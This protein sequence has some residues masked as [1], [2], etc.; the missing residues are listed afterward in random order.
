L[1]AGNVPRALKGE[2]EGIGAG[3]RVPTFASPEPA[4]IALG[5]VARYADWRRRDVGVLP[6]YDDVD[7]AAARHL[8]DRV[9]AERP[10]GRWLHLD[11]GAGLLSSYGIRIAPT[12]R[13]IDAEGAVAEAEAMGFPVV[14]KAASGSLV[15]KTELGAVR[16]GLESPAEVREAFAQMSQRLGEQLGGVVVQPMVDRGVETI[17][18]V[19]HDRSFGPLVMF[20]LGGVATEL[21]ADRAFRILP[22]TDVDAAEL[23][24][25][26]KGSPL[27]T[28]YRGAEPSDLKALEELIMRLGALVQDVPEIAELDCN[29]VAST[30]H[31]AVALDVKVRLAPAPTAGLDSVRSLL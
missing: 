9:L 25:S 4:A 1:G 18:G 11:E 26:L 2:G 24:R 27:L 5:R 31:G 6:E 30:P 17:V 23:V 12:R 16:V 15:H 3:V 19:V 29:P 13:A 20:G 8:V 7:K 14:L 10:E 28:G 21:L 22:I